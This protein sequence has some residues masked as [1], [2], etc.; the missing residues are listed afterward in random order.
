MDPEGKGA[1]APKRYGSYGKSK[2]LQWAAEVLRAAFIFQN[3]NF[4]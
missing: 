3:I 2:N 1:N 4:L